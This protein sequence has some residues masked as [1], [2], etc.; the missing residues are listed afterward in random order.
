MHINRFRA[1]VLSGAVAISLCGLYSA[2]AQDTSSRLSGTITDSSGSAVPSATVVLTNPTTGA[3]VA[4]VT[5]NE[6]GEYNALQLPPGTYTVTVNA[7][8]FRKTTTSIQLSVAS[9]VDLPISLQ[10]G[11]AETTVQVTTQAEMLNREDATVSTLI[12][13]QDVATLPLPNREITNLLALAPGVVHGGAA[14]AVNTAQLSINGSRTLNNEVLLDGSSVIEGVTGQVSRLPSP[15]MLGEFRIITANAPAEYGRTSGGV[16]TMLSRS[17]TDSLHGGVYELFRNAVLNANLLTNKLQTPIVERPANN[18]NQ[19]GAIL[20]GPVW[21]PHVYDGRHRTF[22]YLNYDQTLQQTPSSQTQTVPSAAFRAGDFSSSP[23]AIYDPLTNAPFPGNIIPA[24]RI[25]PAAR[26]I[27]SYVPLPNTT[28]SFDSVSNRY[29]N[30][31]Y[32]QNSVPFTA[33]RYSGRLDH[34]IGDKVRLYASV[35][36]WNSFSQQSLAF[37]SPILATGLSCDCLQGWEV[38]TGGTATLNATTVVDI[39]FGWNRWVELR[40]APSQGVDPSVAFG[41]ARNP[42]EEPPVINISAYSQLGPNASSTSQTYSNTFTPYGS[43]TKVIGP[44]TIK[45]GALLRKDQVNVFNPGTPFT[46]LTA[47]PAASPT[48]QAPAAKPPTAWPTSCWAR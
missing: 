43:I 36:R 21:I 5:S 39:R 14:T 46:E 31:Y 40:S 37:N 42:M 17:G 29:T 12:S 33:P 2:A 19:F 16:V 35:N 25:D 28:G 15:D 47:S 7:S 11:S 38:S 26:K 30:N 24:N 10:V 27:L 8:G 1:A 4:H 9:R 3:S 45:A 6:R 48:I 32:F 20:G 23:A 22:F 41:I 44:H 34:A 18:Y 13:P